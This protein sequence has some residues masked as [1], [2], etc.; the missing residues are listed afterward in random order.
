MPD[1]RVIETMLL[2]AIIEYESST[3][4]RL[5]TATF[6]YPGH[7]LTKLDGMMVDALRTYESTSGTKLT[8]VVFTYERPEFGVP[9]YGCDAR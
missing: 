1:S 5:A 9:R 4:T 3:G 7:G 2:S 8:S 6:T